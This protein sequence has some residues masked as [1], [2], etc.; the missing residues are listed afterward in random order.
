MSATAKVSGG[1]FT[2]ARPLAQPLGSDQEDRT[3][4]EHDADE[5]Q[6]N[7]RYYRGVGISA[8]DCFAKDQQSRKEA[9]A[10]RQGRSN[11]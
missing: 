2:G 10:E 4:K 3:H 11:S 1:L 8:S 5:N 9:T 7:R 6:S